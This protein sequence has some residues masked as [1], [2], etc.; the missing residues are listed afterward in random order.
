MCLIGIKGRP[1][2]ASNFVS[3]VLMEPRGEHSQKPDIVRDK[4]VELCGDLPRLEMFARKKSLKWET[5]GNEV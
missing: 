4:I 1:P 3:S 2:I 5:W